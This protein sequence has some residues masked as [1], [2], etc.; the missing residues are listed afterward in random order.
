MLLRKALLGGKQWIAI[1]VVDKRLFQVADGPVHLAEF[2]HRSYVAGAAGAA[3][4]TDSPDTS[5]RPASRGRK[6]NC[7]G[8]RT[9]RFHP[10]VGDPADLGR[11]R[12]FR[13]FGVDEEHPAV[14]AVGRGDCLQRRALR[15]AA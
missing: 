3:A 7:G 2:V 4:G 13:A 11:Q 10:L 12:W 15:W 6:Y 1:I 14:R 9:S 5:P 8:A